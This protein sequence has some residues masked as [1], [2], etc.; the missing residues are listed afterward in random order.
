MAE[1][2]EELQL[3]LEADDRERLEILI[4]EGNREDFEALKTLVEDEQ[5]SSTFRRKAM[6]ALG[7]WPDRQEEAVELIQRTLPTMDELETITA[8][9]TLGRIGTPRARDVVLEFRDAEEPDVRRQVVNAL[10]RIGTDEAL[11]ALRSMVDREEVEPIRRLGRKKLLR[12]EG[13]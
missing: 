11:E 1:L 3:A 6:Y 10:G 5:T 9:S 4:D 8:V 2:R 7:K 12:R 13:R